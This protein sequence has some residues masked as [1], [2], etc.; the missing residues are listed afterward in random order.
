LTLE[1]LRPAK[2]RIVAFRLPMPDAILEAPECAWKT[3][4][5]T[6]FLRSN[7]STR[8]VVEAVGPGRRAV[9]GERIP[10]EVQ[11]G[12]VIWWGPYI[13]VEDGDRVLLSEQDIRLVEG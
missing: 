12:D 2:D 13:D 8:G 10:M 5:L 3:E 4:D 6:G 9:N 11:P 1:G 7:K